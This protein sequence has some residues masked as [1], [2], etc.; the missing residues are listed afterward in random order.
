MGI[1]QKIKEKIKTIVFSKAASGNMV[2]IVEVRTKELRLTSVITETDIRIR[3]TFFFPITIVW[4][5][6]A[7]LNR[8]GLKVGRMNFE[9]AQKIKGNSDRILTT[10]SEISI[11]TS[12]FQ[13]LS[14]LLMQNISMQSVGSAKIKLLWWT[15]EIPVNDLFE[16]HPSKLKII[17]DET[18]EEKLLRKQRKEEW[19]EKKKEFVE[20]RRENRKEFKEEILKEKYGEDYISKEERQKNK[21][22]FIITNGEALKSDEEI[23]STQEKEEEII[24]NKERDDKIIEK[25]DTVEI[26]NK[27]DEII[28]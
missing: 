8:D 20:N 11:I 3:N 5:K 9:S 19:K 14:T 13:A 28:E 21:I 17:K 18:E 2:D 12:L 16:I 1:I 24:L 15:F 7:L 4:I 22:E 25:E 26:Q 10:T 27:K 23:I 6:T